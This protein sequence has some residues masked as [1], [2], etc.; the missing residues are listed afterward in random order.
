VIIGLWAIFIEV[1]HVNLRA[2]PIGNIPLFDVICAASLVTMFVIFARRVG[3]DV[4]RV[5]YLDRPWTQTGENFATKAKIVP[6][7][8]RR[9]NFVRHMNIDGEGAKGVGVEIKSPDKSF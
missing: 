5:S 1:L 7:A 2:F 6:I 4:E 8:G 9:L 3:R